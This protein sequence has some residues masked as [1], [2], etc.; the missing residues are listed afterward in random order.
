M[1]GP[2]APRKSCCIS[3]SIGWPRIT[4]SRRARPATACAHGMR[5]SVLQPEEIFVNAVEDEF[6]FLVVDGG[7]HRDDAGRVLRHQFGDLQRGIERVAGID[8]LQEFR[9]YLDEADQAFADDMW[10]QPR[11]R[12]REAQNLEPMR[13]RRGVTELPAIFDVVMDR[14][15]VEADGLER[16]EVR[17]A[18]G[19]RGAFENLADS[20]LLKAAQRQDAM[21]VGFEFGHGQPPPSL[22]GGGA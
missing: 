12:S 7:A 10:K 1:R 5:M 20:K 11:A 22:G 13:Q 21:I 16:R 9:A 19:A 15:I 17:I 4:A 14:M 8:R 18:D 6:G 3:R 2:C